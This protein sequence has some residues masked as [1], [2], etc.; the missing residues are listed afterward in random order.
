MW[1]WVLVGFGGFVFLFA[2]W[3]FVGLVF[4]LGIV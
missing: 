3:W 1:V 2:L 4:L